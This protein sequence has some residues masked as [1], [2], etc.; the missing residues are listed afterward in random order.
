MQKMLLAALLLMASTLIQAQDSDPN[1][2]M[3]SDGSLEGFVVG[4]QYFT[5]VSDANLRE[6]S[7][8]QSNVITKLA[9]ATPVEIV[10]V[11]TDS[12][13]LRGVKLP[14]VQV[15]VRPTGKPEQI[16][17]LW[18]GFL[19]LAN[20]QTPNEEYMPNAGVQFLTGV[21]AYDEAKHQITVQVRAAKDGK[22]LS[23]CEFTTN[24]DLSYYPSFEVIFESFPKVKAVLSVN[25]YYPACGY[26]SGNNLLFWQEN[27]QLVKVLETSSV[28]DGGV[29]Y[30]SEEF[31]LPSQRGGIGDH[32]I[33]T[34]DH[35]E[36][37]EK[38]DDMVRTKQSFGIVLYKWNGVKLV[39]TKEIK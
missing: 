15:R 21:S 13:S 36:F 29:F 27:N 17:Y 25:Y 9:I 14:W 22:E 8:T 5:L 7:N 23:K 33:V 3:H 16:G 19:A 37:E 24:G 12:L 4:S 26:P 18:G 2:W 31:I 38:G 10:S 6:K 11:S 32:I 34:H 35:S 20:I 28:S 30:D 1:S 39:K